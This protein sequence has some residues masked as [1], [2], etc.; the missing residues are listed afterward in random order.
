MID[1]TQ[2]VAALPM[3]AMCHEMNIELLGL[4]REPIPPVVGVNDAA[5]EARRAK[6]ESLG[7][8]Q[9]PKERRGGNAIPIKAL[10]VRVATG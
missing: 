10:K 5:E 9:S 2:A 1:A 3:L 6:I 8:V 7:S 4:F